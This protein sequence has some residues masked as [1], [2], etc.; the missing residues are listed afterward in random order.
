MNKPQSIVKQA[1]I[2]QEL[3][4]FA[5]SNQQKTQQFLA[6]DE[7]IVLIK[8]SLGHGIITLSDEQKE[9]LNSIR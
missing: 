9:I 5:L 6:T 4:D 2:S 3:A 1:S 7:T 8:S